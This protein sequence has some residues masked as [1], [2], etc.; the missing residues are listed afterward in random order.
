MAVTSIKEIWKGRESDGT[1]EETRYTRVLRV[2][3]NDGTDGPDVIY[4]AV[5]LTPWL[6]YPGA[7]HPE[8]ALAKC[9][10]ARP[11]P[12]GSPVVW[13][14]T[15]S[16][17]NKQDLQEDPADDEITIEWEE[18]DQQR[19]VTKDRNGEAVLNSAGDPPVEPLMADDGNRILNITA[20]VST[21]PAW[22]RTY[23]RAINSAA[24]TVDGETIAAKY[25]QVRRISCSWWNYRGAYAYRTLKIQIALKDEDE[26][27]FE[28]HWLDQGFRRKPT[29]GEI[30]NSTYSSGDRPRIRDA[31][32][33]EVTDAVLLDGNGQPL[34]NPT[35]SSAVFIETPYYPL[36]TFGGII[37]GC[38]V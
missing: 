38:S 13:V 6:I 23:R 33:A 18:E 29:A 35:E 36:K 12:D 1:L 5:A 19:P 9:I 22:T 24:F 25:A 26:P 21:R 3:T 20:N 37:P 4:A 15:A 30:S 10:G 11:A 2:V 8:N 16:Y 28:L 27:N 17:S 14:V 7:A 32:G 34:S 31:N